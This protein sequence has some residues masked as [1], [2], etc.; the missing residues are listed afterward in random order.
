MNMRAILVTVV[1]AAALVLTTSQV[2]SQEKGEQGQ[3]PA[4]MQAAMEQWMKLAAPGEPHEEMA[5]RAG[6][7]NVES[8]TWWGGPG[9]PPT[10]SQGTSEVKPI[11]GGR[12]VVEKFQSEIM[13]GGQK[14]PMEGMGI[15]GYDNYKK[16]YTSFW[17][18]NMGTQMMTMLGSRAPGS[19]K[20]TYYGQMDEPMLGVQDRTVKAVVTIVSEDK[21]TF[22]MYDLHAGDNYKVMELV[23]TRKK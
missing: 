21:H 4:E 11:L 16:M 5:H 22:E 3:M 18:D 19:D 10:I 8:K 2:F 14:M 17:V 6:T 23:Y 1:L 13:M 9:T 12:F 20:I 7:W 15:S